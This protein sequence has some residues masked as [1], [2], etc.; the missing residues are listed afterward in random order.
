MITE[1]NIDGVNASENK[2]KWK[3][4]ALNSQNVLQKS[5]N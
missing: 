3:I 1:H 5:L 2:A 4:N